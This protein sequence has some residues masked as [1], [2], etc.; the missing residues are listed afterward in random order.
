[1]TGSRFIHA[2]SVAKSCATHLSTND[3]L[4]FLFM[5]RKMALMNLLAE[6]E[7]RRR[8]REETCGHRERR[9][10]WDELGKQCSHIHTT[11]YKMEKE[12]ATHSCLENS[13]DREAWW[14]TVRGVAE[15]QL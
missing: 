14:A 7:Y 4:L 11:K 8:H 5:A 1:M 2:C 6:R 13:K 15:S 10:R 12:M 9:G 3:L